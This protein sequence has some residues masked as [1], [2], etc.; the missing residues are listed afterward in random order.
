MRLQSPKKS[1]ATALLLVASLCS[2]QY[3]A[4][5]VT[6]PI[7]TKNTALVLHSDA[8]N[9]LGTVYFG[10]KLA[11]ATEYN[12][13]SSMYKQPEDYTGV[14]NAAYTSSGSRNLFEPAISVRH[15]DGNNSLDL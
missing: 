2:S 10:R 15:A 4:A 3:I 14:A 5:Q 1:L 6:I 11:Q 13:I 7:E 9:S 8:K 12:A